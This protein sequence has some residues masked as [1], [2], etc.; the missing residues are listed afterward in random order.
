MGTNFTIPCPHCRES[1]F[2]L[3]NYCIHCGQPLRKELIQKTVFSTAKIEGKINCPDCQV[4]NLRVAKFCCYCGKEF[5]MKE[6]A[7]EN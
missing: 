2:K 6:V 5:Q 4:S 3:N 1:N 7:K